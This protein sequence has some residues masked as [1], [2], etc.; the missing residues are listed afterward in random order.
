MKIKRTND[1][2]GEG[3]AGHVR[4]HSS[5]TLL[6]AIL[7]VALSSC[8]KKT[9]VVAPEWDDRETRKVISRLLGHYESW[10]SVPYRQGGN[11]KNGID[12]SG[13]VAE[14]FHRQFGIKLPR[15][16]DRLVETG[17]EITL[18]TARPGDL[19]FFK[20]GLWDR[21]VGIVLD[22]SRFLHASTSL[23]VTVSHLNE[24]YWRDRLWQVRRILR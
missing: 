20:T 1:F 13:F 14:T 11:S 16:T 9:I 6:M 5:V 8:T 22:R 19:I 23:G 12:C 7:L 3:A 4:I 17:D 10:R 18:A 21:H 24:S 2:S 15:T